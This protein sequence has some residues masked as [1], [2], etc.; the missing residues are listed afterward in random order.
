MIKRLKWKV[1]KKLRE[2]NIPEEKEG[3]TMSTLDFDEVLKH[4]GEWGPYQKTL[5]FMLCIPACLPAAFLAFNQVFLSAEPKHWCSQ[6]GLDE[7]APDLNWTHRIHLGSPI[8]REDEGYRLYSR[9]K[10][11]KV[12]NWTD[13]FHNNGGAWPEQPDQ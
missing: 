2:P 11:Y 4:L 7:A 3:R 9:C 6:P 1:Q 13:V 5:Y 12:D 10:M 8:D